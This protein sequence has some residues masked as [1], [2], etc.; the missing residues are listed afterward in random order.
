ME[1]LTRSFEA[2]H[3]KAS[4][5][6]PRLALARSADPHEH[7]RARET[8]PQGRLKND[9]AQRSSIFN[10]NCLHAELLQ[11]RPDLTVH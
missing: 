4:V 1:V 10:A 5:T 11:L 9:G 8:K 6:S 7:K 3:I 2:P